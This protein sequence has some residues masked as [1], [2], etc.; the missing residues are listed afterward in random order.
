MGR[1]ALGPVKAQCLSVGEYQGREVGRS[2][3]EWVGEGAPS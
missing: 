3:K 2:G 1:E